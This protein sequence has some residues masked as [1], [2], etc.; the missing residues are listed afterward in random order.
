M[1]SATNV[2]RKAG[3]LR[4]ARF[5]RRKRVTIL[6]VHGVMSVQPSQSWRPFRSF[7]E[8]PQLEHYI[9]VL[10]RAYRFVSLSEAV[11]MLS[12]RRPM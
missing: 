8:P 11:H 9:H 10:Q 4:V 12:G 2:L 3:A 6:T 5:W 1:S 7:L